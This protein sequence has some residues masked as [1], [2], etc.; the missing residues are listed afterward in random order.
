[1]RA[2]RTWCA[3]ADPLQLAAIYEFPREFR[4]VQPGAGAVP[5]GTVPPQPVDRG[6]VPARL[7]FLRRAPHHGERSGARR[8][9]C[10][11]QAPGGR[12]GATG[13]FQRHGRRGGA[14][15]GPRIVG[16]RKVPQWL[17]LGH[18]FNDLLLADTAAK[19]ASAS[20]IRAS[21]PRRILLLTAALL[22]LVY[23]VA[24]V[25]SFG[26]NRRPWPTT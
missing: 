9:A 13:I 7:L 22:C 1:M 15:A 23:S 21:M 10:R 17:F 16:Q 14:A 26:K 6:A 20:S 2:P 5:G 4:K 24:L 19:G 3:R 11:R 8:P 25:I 12:V 18:F